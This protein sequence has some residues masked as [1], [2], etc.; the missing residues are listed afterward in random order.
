MIVTNGTGTGDALKV[1]KNNRAHTQAVT[2]GEALHSAELG[3]GY[4]INTGLVSISA[5]TALLYIK[6]DEDRDLVFETLIFGEFEG[7]THSDD[8][9]I[10][11]HKNATA[12]T[13]ISGATA[14][15]MN[16]NRNF[17][18]NKTL[19]STTLAY[20]GASGNTVTDGTQVALLQA[21]PGARNTY[22]IDLILPKGSSIVIK[23][24]PN[25]SSGSA[26]CYAAA[27]CYLKDPEGQDK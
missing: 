3:D 2:E 12:G 17:G 11:I 5:D 21:T 4:N 16:Q 20:K 7:I 27:I 22:P 13:L 6:N 23:V 10:T 26:N 18:S 1:D 25:A 9:Y 24:H 19:G 8:P 15:D 14:V